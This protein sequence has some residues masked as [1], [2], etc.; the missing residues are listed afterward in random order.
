MSSAAVVIGALRTQG[1]N[2]LFCEHILSL[3]I[4]SRLHREVYSTAK[5]T[6]KFVT[7]DTRYNDTVC[8]QRFCCKIEFTVI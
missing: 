8:Y 3:N 7:E 1:V 2:L 5:E 4:R 6:R